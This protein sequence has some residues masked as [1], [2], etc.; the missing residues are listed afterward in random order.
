M[1]GSIKWFAGNHVAANILMFVFIIGGF[2][3]AGRVDQE[4]FPEIQLDLVT[5]TM[6]Y[7]GAGPLEVED[8]IIRPIEQAIGGLENI[9]R[10]NGT[11]SEGRGVVSAELVEGANIDEVLNNIKSEVDRVQTFPDEAEDPVI[12]KVTNRREAISLVVYGDASDVALREH[13]ERIQDDLLA[14]PNITQVEL[15]AIRPY[16][17]SIEIPEERLRSYN[18]TLNDVAGIVRQASLDLAGGSVKTEGGEILLRT[19]EKRYVG[20]DFENITILTRPDGSIVKL[21]DVAT[22]KDGFEDLDK[23]ASFDG[24]PAVMIKVFRVGKQTPAEVAESVRAYIADYGKSLPSSIKVD[25]WQD[26]SILLDQRLAL[27]INNGYQGLLLL[28]IIIGL[29]LEVR[30]AFWVAMGIPVSFLGAI[31]LLPMFDVS[32]NMLSLFAFI[33]ALGLVLDDAI[34]IGENV[35]VHREMGKSLFRASV[36]STIELAMPITFSIL[37]TVAAFLPMIFVSGAMGKF[38]IVIPIIMISVLIISLI[39]SFYILPAHLCGGL[40]SSNASIWKKIEKTRHHFDDWVNTFSEKYYQRLVRSATEH[41]YT[42]IAIATAIM[43][44]VFGIVGGGVIK[45][46]FMPEI[47]ADEIIVSVAMPPGTPI[48][49]TQEITRIIEQK[50]VELAAEYDS[51]RTDSLKNVEHVFV[52]NGFQTFEG[53]PRG[54]TDI[55]GA[56]YGQVRMLFKAPDVRNV[57]TTDFAD[58]WRERVGDLPGVDKINFQSELIKSGADVGLQLSHEDFGMLLAA[59]ERLKTALANYQGVGDIS[60]SHAEGKR[61]LQLTLRPEARTLGITERDMAQQVRSAFF[62]AEA[63]RMQRGR[64]EV[65]VMVRYPEDDRQSLSNVEHMYVRTRTGGEVPFTAAA[66]VADGVGYSEITRTDRK[67]VVQ[68]T[69]SVNEALANPDEIMADLQNGLLTQLKHD[70]PGLNIDL[71]GESRDRAESMGSLGVGFL[72]SLFLI[73]GLLAIPFKSFTQ[74]LIVMSVIPFGFVGAV[75]GHLVYGYNLSLMS[76]FGLVALAGVVVNGALILIDTVNTLRD[77]GIPI[78]EA[79][80]QAGV[81]RFRPIL[82]TMLTTFFGLLPLMSDQSMQAQFLIPMAISLAFGE[83]ATTFIVLIVIPALYLILEDVHDALRL[84]GRHYK[85]IVEDIE[86]GAKPAVAE[87]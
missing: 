71:E 50:G 13:A 69:A 45:F 32:I 2:L 34:V 56:H 79:V 82:L 1:K 17:I 30:L 74:P 87:A 44:T 55:N 52:G 18:L 22:V 23:Y 35:H 5:V 43:F 8:G 27:L 76:M 40:S 86:D 75:L 72:F 46:V 31:L 61:E 85:Q 38:M 9:K 57:V 14:L 15:A 81:R 64:N 62:G 49:R 53:G 80:L 48:E 51:K 70:Y 39:D 42:T 33:L 66:T 24:K 41:R 20:R 73:Y 28:L 36:D 3:M 84:K 54:V 16:E 19:K 67:R 21:G 4:V 12:A 59:T 58:Q 10:I 65:K 29:F 25:I 11:A 78:R 63:L 77:Q 6:Q 37:T 7:P 26:W 60:D 47:D 68:V 83:L